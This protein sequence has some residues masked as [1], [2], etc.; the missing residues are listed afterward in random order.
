M[1]LWFW[2]PR[3]EDVEAAEQAQRD[4]DAVKDQ[5]PEVHAQAAA[6]VRHGQLNGWTQIAKTIFGGHR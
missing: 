3:R 1:R 4:L 5:W 6:F 2:C